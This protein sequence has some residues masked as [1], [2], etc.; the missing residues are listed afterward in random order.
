MAIKNKS[1]DEFY[2]GL[3]R[4]AGEKKFPLKVLFELTYRCNFRCVHCYNV[5]EKKKELTTAQV[6]KILT[7]LSKAGCF[8]VGFT[9]GEPLMRKDIF[10]ILDHAKRLG[11]RIT[12]LTNG[13]LV[14]PGVAD[15]IAALGTSLNKVDISFLGADRSTFEAIT[16]KK[17]SHN[18]V[19]NAVRL[20]RRRDAPVMIKPT[21]MRQ[22][23]D[24]F[25]KIK[26]IADSFGCMFKYSPTLNAKTDGSKAPL[27]YRL[28]PREVSEALK[29]FSKGKTEPRLPRSIKILPGKN[30]FFRCGS[31]K[32]EASIN[33][34]GELKLCPEI[35]R[36]VYNI[37]KRSLPQAWKDL[38]RFVEKLES[39]RYVCK[40]C[41]LA[42]FCNSCPARML[43]EE[44]SLDKCNRYDKEFAVL[45][46]KESGNWEAIANKG[47][48]V[49]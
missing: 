43:V 48:S 46:A 17:G 5:K 37:L 31:G 20:L 30:K 23:K 41:Y 13:Y 40:S 18:K 22:N 10:K 29:S 38:T 35:N 11:L 24:E 12:I 32:A 44:G 3:Y 27:Q 45:R 2:A 33:P 36:P 28:S 42:S 47:T 21:L 25:F 4:L 8:H 6:K 26:G 14:N 16:R 34:Y 7:G 19:M 1:S 39:A 49:N 9:G 15:K